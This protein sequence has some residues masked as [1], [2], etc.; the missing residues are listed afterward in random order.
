MAKISSAYYVD[1][2]YMSKKYEFKTNL[3]CEFSYNSCSFK[4]DITDRMVDELP[5]SMVEKLKQ[6]KHFSNIKE[7]DGYFLRI[8]KECY[9]NDI[10]STR[11]YLLYDCI[12]PSLI[13]SLETEFRL[14]LKYFL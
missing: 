5:K 13:T 10:V 2:E 1:Y 3:Y 14:Y 11:K 4:V 8:H 7:I 12:E 9:E 6:T